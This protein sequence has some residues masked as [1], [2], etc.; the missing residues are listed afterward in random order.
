MATWIEKM[1]NSMK[2]TDDDDDFDDCFDEEAVDA[3]TENREY[4]SINITEDA[5]TV[6]ADEEETAEAAEVA[7]ETEETE[8]TTEAE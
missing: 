1:L 3:T 8:E 4:V 2:L 6:D 7:E 5:P